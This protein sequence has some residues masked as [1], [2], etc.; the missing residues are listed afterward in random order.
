MQW[1][2]YSTALFDTWRST[3]KNIIVQACPGSGKTTNLVHMC[4]EVINPKQ[5]TAYLA[6]GKDMVKEAKAKLPIRMERDILTLNG[7]G[8]R[9][10]M[11]A[12]GTIK[13]D[14]EDKLPKV[15]RLAMDAVKQGRLEA[16]IAY[17]ERVSNVS[18]AVGLMKINI[19]LEQDEILFLAMCDD[20][21]IDVYPNMFNDC[22]RILVASDDE[23]KVIDFNDQLRFPIIYN[24]PLP[25][26]D[27]GVIDESQDLSTI[28][29]LMLSR[30]HARF[31]FVGDK[32]QSMYVFRGAMLDAMEQM[33]EEFDCVELPL[34]LSYRCSKAVVNEAR[35]LFDDIEALE[36]AQE[37][38]VQIGMPDA[39]M[40]ALTPND[41]VLCRLNAPLLSY[42]YALL[43]SGIACHVA[44]RDIGQGLIKLIN[45]I[46]CST[47]GQFIDG[48]EQWRDA[49]TAKAI[50]KGND[51]KIQSIA[52]RADSVMV[53]VNQCN[54]TDSIRE[55]KE[56]IYNLFNAGM[57]VKLS[58]VHKAK[59][60]E[61]NNAYILCSDLMPLQWAIK[62][63]D[64]QQEYNIKYVA[65]TRAKNTITYM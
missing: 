34:K 4:N 26:Y 16:R 28:Q 6:F 21:D 24:L 47:V 8:H 14:I 7:L 33:K 3:D 63:V 42:A 20:R 64:K 30:I 27:N 13:M 5:H 61:A 46:P 37:G 40:P 57:G 31:C 29:R 25:Q 50:E 18:K 32:R 12:F 22:V 15:Y 2:H 52:D 51:H 62:P 38:A 44:G 48:L 9:A 10:I 58:S 41:I 60:L 11:S 1:S 65:I 55:I 43:K 56:K 19:G 23:K 17:H 53:F 39:Y 49:E 59:G 54:L 36:T 35:L 45:K